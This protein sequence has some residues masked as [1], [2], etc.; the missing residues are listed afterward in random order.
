MSQQLEIFPELNS[1]RGGVPLVLT[2]GFPCQDLSIAG[3]RRGLD[4][5]RS[6][7]FF[8]AIRCIRELRPDV[9]IFENVKGLFTSHGGR[10]FVRF[11]QEIADL[12][13]YVCQWQLVDTD[14][15]LPQNRER[16]Y[17]VGCSGTFTGRQVFPLGGS[18]PPSAV[19]SNEQALCITAT[20]GDNVGNGSYVVESKRLQKV[21]QINRMPKNHQQDRVYSTDGS[22]PCLNALSGGNLEPKIFTYPRGKNAG[23]FRSGSCPTITANAFPQN[24]MVCSVITPSF[25]N[26]KQNGRVFKDNG[27]PSFT[28]TARDNPGIYNG[29]SIRKLTPLE[30]ERLQGFPDEWTQSNDSGK[31]MSDSVR[32]K[33]LGN[34]VSVPVPEAIARALFY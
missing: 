5:E 31:R 12:G 20:Y 32:Y 8:E 15:F 34:A 30:C 13:G 25:V 7:L 3:K 6:G 27:E 28:L 24:N 19:I 22:A 10:D 33:A 1:D 26:K 4:G 9:F 23:G 2:A 11:L 14:W 17:F 21:K 29:Q 16:I 18:N